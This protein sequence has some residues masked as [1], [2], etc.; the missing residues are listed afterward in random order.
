MSE[1]DDILR[2]IQGALVPFDVYLKRTE[3]SV[4]DSF[5][6]KQSPPE[7]GIQIRHEVLR[8]TQTLELFEPEGPEERTKA[9]RFTVQTGVRFVAEP[10][11]TTEAA[12]VAVCAEVEAVWVIE[13]R[14]QKP[15]AVDQAGIDAFG[16]T[17]NVMYHVWPYWREFIHASCARLRLPQII[18][19]MF[20]VKKR[21]PKKVIDAPN[22]ARA[23]PQE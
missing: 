4:A 7:L 5:D 12:E 21:V 1:E 6:P 15:D 16:Q 17:G 11:S 14:I 22:T 19:P 18:L 23:A 3:L 2:R 8:E 20:Q 9:L 13:Y 10:D